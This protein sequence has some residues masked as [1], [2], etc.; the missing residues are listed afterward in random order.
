MKNPLAFMP[1]A[2]PVF[3]VILAAAG[4]NR[5]VLPGSAGDLSTA[6]AMEVKDGSGQVV[7]SGTFGEAQ[8]SG[9]ERERE[10]VLSGPAGAKGEAEI[11]TTTAES[12]VM[13][14]LEVELKGVAP[15]AALTL[16]VDGRQVGSLIADSR[17]AAEIELFGPVGR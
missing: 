3:A 10:A 1:A 9:R 14:E 11:E 13:Q 15:G 5:I 7:L 8:A 16:F 2:V 6:G 17:G 12:Q 4:E